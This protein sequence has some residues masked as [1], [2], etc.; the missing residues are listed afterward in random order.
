[1]TETELKLALPMLPE[2]LLER[3]VG[4]LGALA[5]LPST[6]ED[7]H[8][9]YYDTPDHALLRQGAVLRVRKVRQGRKTVWLQTFKTSDRR[10]SALSTRGEWE[11]PLGG[12][13]LSQALL[14]GTPWQTIDPEGQLFGQLKP[15]FVTRFSRTR[16][17]C[18]GPDDSRIEVALDVGQIVSGER[19]SPIRELELE[20]KAGPG[21]ALLTLAQ[22]LATGLPCIPASQSKSQRGYA[23]AGHRAPAS[24]TTT[25]GGRD[26]PVLQAMAVEALHDAFAQ[27]TGALIALCDQEDPQDVHQAR[28][29]W[30][31]LRSAQRLFRPVLDVPLDLSLAGLQPLLDELTQLREL[32][33]ART[34]SLPPLES[35]FVAGDPSRAQRWQA[36][37]GDLHEAGTR[38]RAR[39][40]EHLATV[41]TGQALL[42][43]QSWLETG[44][45][46][47][48]QGADM[49][50]GKETPRRWARRRLRRL[51][52][53][54]RQAC[55]ALGTPVQADAQHHAR[56][57]A[58]RLRYGV[59]ALRGLLP[60]ARARRWHRRALHWQSVLG[61]QRD[62][63]QA[64]TRVAGLPGHGDIAEFLRG[65]QAGITSTPCAGT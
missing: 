28:V 64:S 8:N 17:M 49:P 23:L 61:Q 63:G 60:K 57:L 39:V 36:M 27:F 54:L 38:S 37:M 44:A 1:M 45:V 55:R 40:R 30:R 47:T 25:G 9:T 33:V 14:Q 11:F 46:A 43:V 18:P 21:A 2:R 29:G 65:Y 22:S 53:A 41:T 42:V 34:Q 5:G 59:E 7:L 19:S 56:I 51:S 62:A 31:R 26:A 58:K 32:D 20:C 48:D 4:A 35:H 15:C 12:P 10:M 52:Q 6:R 3:R 13:A 24:R 50:H 16:W